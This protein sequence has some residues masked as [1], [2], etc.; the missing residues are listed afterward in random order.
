[1]LV[2]SRVLKGRMKLSSTPR[3]DISGYRDEFE[4]GEK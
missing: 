1:M 4:E 3:T 2:R